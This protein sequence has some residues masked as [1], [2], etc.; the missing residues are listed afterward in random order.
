[1]SDEF[2]WWVSAVF[3]GSGVLTGVIR[4]L[5][6]ARGMLDVPNPRS[7]HTLPTPRGGG[8]AIVVSVLIAIGAMRA[9]GDLPG[10]LTAAL[11]VGGPIIALI[12]FVDDL[13]SV[14][15]AVR[16]AVQFAVVSGC[17]WILGPPPPIHF[18]FAVVNFG[19]PGSIVAI[20]CLVWFLNLFNFMDGIDGIASIEVIS[21]MTFATLLVLWQKGEPSAVCLLLTGAAAVAGFL[22]WNWPPARI[23]MGD[24]GSGFLGFFAGTV[25][26]TTIVHGRFSIWV[27]LILFAAFIVDS[28]VTL[29]RRWSRGAKLFEAHRSHAYQRLSRKYRS[30]LKVTLGTLFV[31]AIWLDPIAV[32]ATLRPSLG[33]LLTLIAWLPLVVAAWLSGAGTEGE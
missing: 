30:H 27:W 2:V 17:V 28:T 25:A 12:G 4:R 9:H 1:M 11:L 16:L 13:R 26:W 8:L 29:L 20:I 31:N 32:A 33:S 7:S 5:A 15:V 19:V 23:F 3:L 14:S 6:L 10:D 21:V 24:A 18:G 22:L